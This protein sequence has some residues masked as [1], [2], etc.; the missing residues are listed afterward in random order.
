MQIVHISAG[1][2]GNQK[3]VP[4]HPELVLERVASST[5]Y[6]GL[7]LNPLQ[8]EQVLQTCEGALQPPYYIHSRGVTTF[9]R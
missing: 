8:E 7:N 1:P 2:C 4:D 5:V 9:K 6:R 3:K